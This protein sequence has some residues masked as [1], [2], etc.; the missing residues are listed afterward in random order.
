[1]TGLEAVMDD[2]STVETLA[3]AV[4]LFETVGMPVRNLPPLTRR[5]YAPDLQDLWSFWNSSVSCCGRRQSAC[6]TSSATSQ[7]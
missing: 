4:A 6:A 7:S 2:R 5:E 1:M 3:Q